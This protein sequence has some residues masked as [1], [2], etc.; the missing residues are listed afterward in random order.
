MF[1]FTESVTITASPGV[2]WTHLV[3]LPRWWIASN[4][5]HIRLEILPSG[6]SVAKG[7]Q[8]D[9][10]EHIAGIRVA[11]TGHITSFHDNT[12]M[13]WEGSAMYH[14]RGVSV[15]A[16]TGMKW[17]IA[18][19]SGLAIVSA[20]SWVEFPPTT[21]GRLMAWHAGK[22]LHFLEAARKHTRRELHYLKEMAEGN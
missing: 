15:P 20:G 17:R 22:H 4:P 13:T 14:Y 12:E 21:K 11:A 1:S 16:Q 5:D 2:I 8:V 10:E 18:A 19:M 3:D 9:F 7:V 6:A